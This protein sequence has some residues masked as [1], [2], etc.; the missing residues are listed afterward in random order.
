MHARCRARLC[1]EVRWWCGPDETRLLSMIIRAGGTN[2]KSRLKVFSD[3]AYTHCSQACSLDTGQAP[4]PS[5]RGTADETI[6][7][8]MLH[9][10]HGVVRQ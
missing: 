6:D 5:P 1:S 9:V 10:G 4:E 7:E 3:V 2:A 8:T